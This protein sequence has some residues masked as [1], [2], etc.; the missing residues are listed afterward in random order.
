MKYFPGSL[1]TSDSGPASSSD[2]LEPRKIQRIPVTADRMPVIQFC[3]ARF[4]SAVQFITND[5]LIAKQQPFPFPKA[6]KRR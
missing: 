6:R 3:G 2:I 4:T 1:S 5:G